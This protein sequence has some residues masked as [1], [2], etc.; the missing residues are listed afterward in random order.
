MT[1]GGVSWI[2]ESIGEPIALER[3]CLF[4][5]CA[6]GYKFGVGGWGFACTMWG[7][8][9][10]AWEDGFFETLRCLAEEHR[11]RYLCCM[12]GSRLCMRVG[13]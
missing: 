7:R 2:E 11:I 4:L 12:S 3:L 10:A 13:G 6:L 9:S 5:T 1:L 8:L